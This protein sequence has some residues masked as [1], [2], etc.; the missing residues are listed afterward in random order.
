M[1]SSS[2]ENNAMVAGASPWIGERLFGAAQ[3]DLRLDSVLTTGAYGER[4]RHLPLFQRQQVVG[5]TLAQHFQLGPHASALFDL[6][7]PRTVRALL[8][9]ATSPVTELIWEVARYHHFSERPSRLQC[10]FFWQTEEQAYQWFGTRTWP[11]TLYEV[12]VVTVQR[13][14]IAD[15]EALEWDSTATTMD[16]AY[17]QALRYW[18]APATV[19]RYPEVLLEGSVRVIQ[20]VAEQPR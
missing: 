3:R 17:T 7:H 4:L 16:A 19:P 11:A 20:A 13:I 1:S 5:D 9:T 10:L 2:E 6:Q 12:E 15:M 18:Q 8:P 14:F